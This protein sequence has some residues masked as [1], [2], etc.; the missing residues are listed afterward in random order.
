VRVNGRWLPG[1]RHAD[2]P[3]RP[4][5]LLVSRCTFDEALVQDGNLVEIF[6]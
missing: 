4:G 3:Y 6:V 1:G 2:N 5:G